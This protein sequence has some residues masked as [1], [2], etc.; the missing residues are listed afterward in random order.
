MTNWR[1]VIYVGVAVALD[2]YAAGFAPVSAT[3]YRPMNRWQASAARITDHTMWPNAPI[4]ATTD[5]LAA[6][7]NAW[8]GQN[9]PQGKSTLQGST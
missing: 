7:F 5:A 3:A 1:G 8:V 6:T 2:T 4:N 9:M